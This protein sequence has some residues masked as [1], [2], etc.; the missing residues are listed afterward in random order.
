MVSQLHVAIT[1]PHSNRQ[2]SLRQVIELGAEIG[3]EFLTGS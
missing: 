2:Q 1:D 3:K